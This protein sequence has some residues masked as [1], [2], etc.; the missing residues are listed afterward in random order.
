M[1][2]RRSLGLAATATLVTAVLTACS[3]GG[4]VASGPAI[5]LGPARGSLVANP[6]VTL[7]SMPSAADVTAA[8]S[9]S[10]SG[11][12]LLALAG[13]PKCGVN[14]HYMEYN[15][16]GAKGEATN[17]TGGIMVP[18]GTDAA[19]TGARPVL[20]YAHGTTVD[21]AYNNA[22]PSSGEGSLLAA[23]YAAQGFIVVTSNFA[24]YDASRL[25][26]HPY[27]NAEQQSNDMV[28]AMRAARA[29][30]P[31]IGATASDK[32]FLSGYSQGGHVS[33]A[34]HKAMQS[35]YANEFKVTASGNMS[36]P[37]S[38]TNTV[39]TVFG[40]GVNAGAT[41]FAP[42]LFTSW[43]QSYGNLYSSPS[44]VYESPY[45]SYVETLLPG[46][47]SITQLY[48]TGKLPTKLF[49]T[50]ALVTGDPSMDALFANGI[51]TPNLIKQ[52]YRTAVLSTPT[53]PVW[54]AAAKNDLLS[55][56]PARPVAL[57]FGAQDPTVFAT[58]SS[59]AATYFA[60]KGA[61]ALVKTMN[62]EDSA[63]VGPT[64]AGAFAAAKAAAAADPSLGASPAERVL[65]S[66][67]GSLVP[68]F[69]NIAVRSYFQGVLAA[70]L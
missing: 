12:S 33:M 8:F 54:A 67:H 52:S 53:H 3:G 65:S 45:A 46:A 58:N 34:T 47:Q 17:A 21:K 22:S 2:T 48:T 64:L 31:K 57:C 50:G 15:T 42:L 4:D 26:Y 49:A 56:T 5:D 44:D 30:F 63:S 14:F 69:C 38:M 9:A 13:T 23:V 25:P 51:G 20:L 18:Q 24:G 43:Q 41:I 60:S 11:R 62:L 35:T 39:R 16:V 59:D 27:L 28:D 66:Y 36:G 40:G 37:Y 19:C 29:A 55:W 61:S 10:A 70:G 1:T 7:A 68:P 32:L 6:P